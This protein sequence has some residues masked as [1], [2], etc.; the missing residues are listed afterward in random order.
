MSLRSMDSMDPPLSDSISVPMVAL[1][2]SVEWSAD[3]STAKPLDFGEPFIKMRLVVLSVF[4]S[5]NPF[6]LLLHRRPLTVGRSWGSLLFYRI[7]TN[8]QV[9]QGNLSKIPRLCLISSLIRLINWVGIL[10][11]TLPM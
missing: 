1:E 8:F 3:F 10:R 4:G 9:E 11:S 6:A 7:L 5:A 2:E